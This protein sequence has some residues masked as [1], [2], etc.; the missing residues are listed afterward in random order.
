M[1]IRYVI[2]PLLV[3]GLFAGTIP[4]AEKTEAN[5]DALKALHEFI[6]QWKGNGETK[7]GKNEL[8]KESAEW[9]WDLKGAEPALKFKVTGGKQFTEGSLKYLADKKKY[10]L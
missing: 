9:S 2:P 1:R 8:W 7:S 5:K 10:Q 4:A 6:G 3:I